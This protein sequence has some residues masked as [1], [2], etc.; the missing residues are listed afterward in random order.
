MPDH[1]RVGLRDVDVDLGGL[2]MGFP[3]VPQAADKAG[4]Q[5]DQ[6]LVPVLLVQVVL[7]HDVVDAWII[8]E[9]ITRVQRVGLAQMPLEHF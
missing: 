5:E 1:L 2:Q 6:R 3:E 9:E 4:V 7:R 8:G